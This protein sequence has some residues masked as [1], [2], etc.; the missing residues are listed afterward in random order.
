MPPPDFWTWVSKGSSMSS[1]THYS[2][3]ECDFCFFTFKKVPKNTCFYRFTHITDDLQSVTSRFTN[4]SAHFRSISFK[5]TLKSPY[6]TPISFWKKYCGF[7]FFSLFQLCFVLFLGQIT[8]TW[9]AL[10][11]KYYRYFSCKKQ[12]FWTK[13]IYFLHSLASF[14]S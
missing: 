11:F 1:G 3:W 8:H 4:S 9:Q 10:L 14:W 7:S 2:S 6:Y 13:S 12:R 5:K